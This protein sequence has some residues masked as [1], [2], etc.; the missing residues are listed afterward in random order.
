M[1]QRVAGPA[2]DKVREQLGATGRGDPA[3]RLLDEEV[4]QTFDVVHSARR[5]GTQAGTS[6]LYYPV[7]RNVH[8]GSGTIAHPLDFYANEIGIIP[9]WPAPVPDELDVWLLAATI[10]QVSGTGTFTGAILM[11]YRQQSQGFGVDDSG[12]AIVA[13]DFRVLAFWDSLITQTREFGLRDGANPRAV[14]GIRLPR[15]GTAL[16]FTSTASALATFDL[17]LDLG[18]FPV[19]LGQD[20]L[21]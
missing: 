20:A 18:L 17:Q 4:V 9:P 8:A 7:M 1:S 13:S 5:G 3:T 16:T 14:L 12:A 15:F 2:L 21:I 10:R 11:D 19:G 6:G